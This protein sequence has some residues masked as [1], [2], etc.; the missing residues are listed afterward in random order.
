MLLERIKN[1]LLIVGLFI[2]AFMSYSVSSNT[3][4][5][6]IDGE[7]LLDMVDGE[8]LGDAINRFDG[9]SFSAFN[10]TYH[11]LVEWRYRASDK[12]IVETELVIYVPSE[13][14]I[15]LNLAIHDPQ[16]VREH[17]NLAGA[18]VPID[19]VPIEPSEPPID[20]PPIIVIDPFEGTTKAQV[21]GLITQ[22]ENLIAADADTAK[23]MRS[24]ADLYGKTDEVKHELSVIKEIIRGIE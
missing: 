8:Y 24:V 2:T 3:V 16:V 17:F 23:A 22:L 4:R 15:N 13:E 18:S 20:L 7:H 9:K 11:T 10:D 1:T 19:P 5:Q 12:S 14:G 6:Y 21:L